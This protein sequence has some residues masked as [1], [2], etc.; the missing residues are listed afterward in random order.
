[1]L[2]CTGS[3]ES[4]ESVS[5]PTPLVARAL[6]QS[7]QS[8][9]TGPSTTSGSGESDSQQAATDEDAPKC[10]KSW[11]FNGRNFNCAGDTCVSRLK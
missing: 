9:Y 1:M 2:E 10:D 6:P 7:S 8:R 4:S 5:N 11:H 3:A